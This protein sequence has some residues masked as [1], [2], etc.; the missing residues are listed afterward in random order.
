MEPI[1]ERFGDCHRASIGLKNENDQYHGFHKLQNRSADEVGWCTKWSGVERG[2]GSGGRE[3]EREGGMWVGVSRF[4]RL[5]GLEDKLADLS[6]VV[7]H[8]SLQFIHL[9]S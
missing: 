9:I 6:Q 2:S 3:R 1:R 5:S 8:L 7:L 4:M